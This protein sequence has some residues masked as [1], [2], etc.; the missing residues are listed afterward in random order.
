MKFLRFILP[1]IL[2]ILVSCKK[3][4]LEGD[5]S[6]LQGRWEWIGSDE[7]RIN[8]A[9]NATTFNFIPSSSDQN[10]YEMEFERKG[11]LSIFKNDNLE[12]EYRVVTSLFE[13]DFCNDLTNCDYISLHLNNRDDRTMTI[14]MN[15]DTMRVVSKHV[16]IP[17]SDYEDNIATYTYTHIFVRNN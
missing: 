5:Y 13:E 15:E 2:L 14:F 9:T 16:N 3:D 10:F 4:K 11:Y 6:I 7:T 17:L 8:K 1:C 12:K